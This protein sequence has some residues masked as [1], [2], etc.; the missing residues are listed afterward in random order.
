MDAL[1]NQVLHQRYQICSKL[2]HKPGSKTF[3]ATDLTTRERVVVK[4]LL[5]DADFT[6]E[7]LKLFE[8]ETAALKELKHTAIP[9]YLDFADVEISDRKGFL[10]VQTYIDAPSLQDWVEQGRTFSEA[11][12]HHIAKDILDILAYLHHRQPSMI[13]RD[14]KPSNVLLSDRSGNHPGQVYLVDFGAIQGPQHGGT[15]TIVGTYGYM[16]L[17]QFGGRAVSA[18]DLYSLGATLVYLA[19]GQHPA[20]LPQQDLRLQFSDRAQLSA[21]FCHWLQW[22]LE[23]DLNQRPQSA[24]RAIALFERPPSQLALAQNTAVKKQQPDNSF[25]FVDCNSASLTLRIPNQQLEKTF[26]HGH[27]LAKAL[28]RIKQV[29]LRALMITMLPMM[30]GSPGIVSFIWL[31]I[32]LWMG[33]ALGFSL[34]VRPMLE[35]VNKIYSPDRYYLRLM[36]K[37]SSSGLSLHLLKKTFW[38][39]CRILQQQLIGISAG[40][41]DDTHYRMNFIGDRSSAYTIHLQGSHEEIQWLCHE[42]NSWT[43][44]E[45]GYHDSTQSSS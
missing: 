9:A 19:T 34:F 23:P 32:L 1:I 10:L 39:E 44:W 2:N 28:V 17:E 11:E 8:R 14:I 38:V 18:S 15:V 25:I 22:L 7:N 12:L 41:Y 13:H 35:Q 45:I 43:G 27:A 31:P 16:P 42:L 26:H 5:F 30:F 36:P 40:P 37:K 20:D 3:L 4:L 21:S 6:W 33:L 29:G 24:E